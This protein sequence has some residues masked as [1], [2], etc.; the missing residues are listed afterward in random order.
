MHCNLSFKERIW[1]VKK[2]LKNNLIMVQLTRPFTDMTSLTYP[3]LKTGQALPCPWGN[4]TSLRPSPFWLWSESLRHI[5]MEAKHKGTFFLSPPNSEG[6]NSLV[7]IFCP[8]KICSKIIPDL[9]LL[10]QLNLTNTVLTSLS[11]VIHIHKA[12]KI[13]TVLTQIP[14]TGE[15]QAWR[16]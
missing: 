15:T 12:Y 3:Q 2:E 5:W 8:V 1:G 14:L 13:G 6:C 16:G 11:Y 7:H 10:G 9:L 4:L